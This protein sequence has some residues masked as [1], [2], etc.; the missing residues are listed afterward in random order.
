MEQGTEDSVRVEQRTRGTGDRVIGDR[1]AEE[2]IKQSD[3]RGT[4]C[5]MR[6]EE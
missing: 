3:S 2:Q 1:G 5:Q 4:R 6:I